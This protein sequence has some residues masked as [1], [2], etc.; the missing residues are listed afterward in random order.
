MTRRLMMAML[1]GMLVM[2]AATPAQAKPSDRVSTKKFLADATV[3]L[4]AVVALRPQSEAAANALIAHVATTCPGVLAAA[5]SPTAAQQ[6]TVSALAQEAGAELAL[7]LLAPRQAAAVAL[8]DKLKLLHWSRAAIRR[9]I[10]AVIA[11]TGAAPTLNPPDLCAEATT[12]KAGGFTSVPPATAAFV[13]LIEAKSG[14]SSTSIRSLLK[15]MKPFIT[16][17]EKRAVARLKSLENRVSDA[18]LAFEPDAITRMLT[19]L[20]GSPTA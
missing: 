17:A 3:Y 5:V 9:A 13:G 8:G 20:T 1:V 12:A 7:A 18:E 4:K 19:A 6:A 15:L 11:K 16:P 10:A 2:V 14:T